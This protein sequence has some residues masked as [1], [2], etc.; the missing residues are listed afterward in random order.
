MTAAVYSQEF[1]KNSRKPLN[2]KAGR[3]LKLDKIFEIRD[4]SGDFY[5]KGPSRFHVNSQGYLFVMDKDQM[6][7]FS[8]EGKFIKNLYK[9]GQ[10]P[11]EISTR[12]QMV[13]YFIFNDEL[14]LYDGVKKIM[15]MDGEGNLIHEIKQTAGRFYK[16]IGKSENG[17]Y[18]THQTPLVR[19]KTGFEEI[20]NQVHL[21]SLDGGTAEKIVEFPSKIYRG[22]NFG[23]DWD[24][25]S[26]VFNQND[27]SLYVTHTCEYNIVRAGL[28][29]RKKQISFNRKY[30]R[31]KY[32]MPEYMKSFY[33]EY[34][35]PKKKYENDILGLFICKN[36]L[37]VKTSKVDKNRGILFDV[38]DSQGRY[39]DNFFLKISG[40]LMLIDGEYIFVT[41][42]NVEENILIKKFKILN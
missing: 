24:R 31:V 26:H 35:P 19:G 23:M 17:F 2:P 10:G 33:E 14:Y 34:N 7:K 38:F 4:E 12:Y 20:N 25:Y 18:L 5:F 27:E 13:S 40:N 39:V 21:V 8:P 41:E 6:L 15:H 9:K 11:G 28:S 32:V 42:R 30:S 29:Q 36:K 3:L 16:L 37:W 22:K 1:I